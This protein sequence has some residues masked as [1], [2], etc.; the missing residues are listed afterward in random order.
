MFDILVKTIITF[1]V[2]YGAIE[3]FSKAVRSFFCLDEQKKDIFVFIHVKNQE[4]SLEYIVRCTIMNYLHRYGGRVVPYIII[5]DKGSCDKTS[6]ISEKICND[7][8]FVYYTTY[9]EYIEFKKQIE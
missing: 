4:N 2:I 1:F 6:E 3:L 5:V 7:Y 8:E 9:D